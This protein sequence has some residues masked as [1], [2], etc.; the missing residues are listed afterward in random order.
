MADQGLHPMIRLA[1]PS[2]DL[3]ALLE[4]ALSRA[5]HVRGGRALVE[6]LWGADASDER[7]AREIDAE[8]AAGRVWVA[9][10][11]SQAVG[12]ALVVQR[13]IRALWVVPTH[14]RRGV[15]SAIVGVLLS[16]DEGPNDAWALPGDRATKSLYESVGWKARLLTMRGE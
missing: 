4:A 16:L 15:A 1:T 12:A 11:G 8:V 5:R 6:Q 3:H 13:C 10:E 7:V 2:D 14:R 9:L